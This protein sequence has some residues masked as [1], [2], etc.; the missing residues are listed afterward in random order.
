M[1]KRNET[2]VILLA[3][4]VC[5]LGL[6]VAATYRPSDWSPWRVGIS[7][8][9]ARR[10]YAARQAR[11]P[12]SHGGRA[13]PNWSYYDQRIARERERRAWDFLEQ[14]KG[15]LRWGDHVA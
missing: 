11:W 13:E 6:I 2:A 8:D 7:R 9:A 4:V 5:L 10:D 15:R 3:C 12:L 14:I 1:H